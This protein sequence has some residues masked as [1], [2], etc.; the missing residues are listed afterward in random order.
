MET[1]PV[2]PDPIDET[3]RITMRTRA[4]FLTA[5]IVAGGLIALLRAVPVTAQ[6]SDLVCTF[7]T[8]EAH[9]ASVTNPPE[10][11]TFR[12]HTAT[13]RVESFQW[14]QGDTTWFSFPADPGTV[15]PMAYYNVVDLKMTRKGLEGAAYSIKGYVAPNIRLPAATF[16]AIYEGTGTAWFVARGVVNCVARKS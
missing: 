11:L 2:N 6:G 8:K 3:R 12:W 13:A 10:Y 7:E 16:A 14:N 1:R 15:R 4:L 9:Y 5:V